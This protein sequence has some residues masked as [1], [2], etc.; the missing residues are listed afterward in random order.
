[1]RHVWHIVKL[2]VS[3]LLVFNLGK[4]SKNKITIEINKFQFG[5]FLKRTEC[6]CG[7]GYGSQGTASTNGLSCNVACPNNANEI[8]GGGDANSIYASG[9]CP[10]M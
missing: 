4:K 1:M 5:L 2:V 10:R 9:S 6:Y 7:M 3:F 8:C